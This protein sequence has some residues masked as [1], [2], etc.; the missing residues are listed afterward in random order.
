MF[1]FVHAGSTIVL[2]PLIF[3][4]FNVGSFQGLAPC[5]VSS[6]GLGRLFLKPL[7]SR[8]L[9]APTFFANNT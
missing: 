4:L 6:R 2:S 3:C 5:F 9:A 8:L 1:S 7:F